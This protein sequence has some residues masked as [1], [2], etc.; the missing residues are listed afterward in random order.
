M[1]KEL[2]VKPRPPADEVPA[3]SLVVAQSIKALH[4]GRATE[5]QQKTALQWILRE[6]CGKAHFPFYETDRDTVFAL[7]RQFVADNIIG[8]FNADLSTLRS[9]HEA[10]PDETR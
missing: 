3:V 5:H 2:K 9:D 1:K 4:D 7:G 10:R 6:A 8:L